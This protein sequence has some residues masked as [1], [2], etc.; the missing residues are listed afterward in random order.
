[1]EGSPTLG[2][3][4]KVRMEEEE[5]IESGGGSRYGKMVYIGQVVTNSKKQT[6]RVAGRGN[7]KLQLPVNGY[8]KSQDI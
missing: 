6:Q 2:T 7:V 4:E 5:I 1:M 8:M 3:G